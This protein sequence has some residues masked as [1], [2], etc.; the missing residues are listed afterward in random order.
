MVYNA[1]YYPDGNPIE[2]CFSKIKRHFK[3]VKTNEIL[4]NKHTSTWSLIDDSF[5]TITKE[6]VRSFAHHSLKLFGIE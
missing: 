2:T 6:E 3:G 1:P 5:K 4:N